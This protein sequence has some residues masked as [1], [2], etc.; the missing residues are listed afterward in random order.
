[1]D[2][3]KILNQELLP[4]NLCYGCGWENPDG[5]K[6][7]VHFSPAQGGQINGTLEPKPHVIGFPG[8]THG[9]AIYTALDCLSTWTVT[10]LRQETQVIWI[11]RSAEIK[12]LKAAKSGQPISLIGKIH[13]QG[14][15][16]NPVTVHAQ[17]RDPGGEILAEGYFKEIP[18]DETK[19]KQITGFK[20]IPENITAFFAHVEK[21]QEV[22]HKNA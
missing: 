20:E 22:I 5:L 13:E 14:A 19:F 9:G 4:Q 3:E 7:K 12:Y 10:V 1:M 15:L 6:I 8:I 17:A 2:I 16:W 21:F 18:L 11:L